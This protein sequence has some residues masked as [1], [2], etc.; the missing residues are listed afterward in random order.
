MDLV[1]ARGEAE[2]GTE[3]D[4]LLLQ[5]EKAQEREALRRMPKGRKIGVNKRTG[6]PFLRKA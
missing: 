6:L 5:Q 1:L 3:S 4:D 2:E